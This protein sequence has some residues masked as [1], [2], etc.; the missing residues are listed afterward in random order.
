MYRDPIKFIYVV[1]TLFYYEHLQESDLD[2]KS[3]K[4]QLIVIVEPIKSS[5]LFLIRW[6]FIMSE[7]L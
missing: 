1:I 4:E 7:L 3:Y 2:K 6:A 5:I